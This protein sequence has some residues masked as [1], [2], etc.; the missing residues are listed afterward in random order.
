MLIIVLPAYN[1]EASIGL[2]LQ[3]IR[4][5]LPAGQCTTLVVD[6]G[7]TDNTAKIA[8][9]FR[10]K[11]SLEI[12]THER[13]LGLGKAMATGLSQSLRLAGNDPEAI[14]ITMDADNTHLPAQIP[15]LLQAI[16]QGADI[17]IASRY[18][19][20]SSIRKVRWLR[21]IMSN[22]VN[23]MLRILFPI[24]G[25][26]DYTCGYRAYRLSLLRQ[27][28]D[29]YGEHFVSEPGFP[30]QVEILAK[31]AAFSPCVAEIPL[32]LRYDQKVGAS[33]IKLAQT[34]AR[35][36]LLIAT[37]RKKRYTKEQS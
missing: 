10:D 3:S 6:D 35:Y 36:L 30:C 4:E 24:P 21:R 7:S 25:A 26:R 5:T 12:I 2:L 33:K 34:I 8:G 1:E 15:E 37:L 18:V 9:S 20:G 32:N 22:T 27:G 31:L 14:V 17:A 28:Y 29:K 11:M 19:S 16:R 13:N 23:T